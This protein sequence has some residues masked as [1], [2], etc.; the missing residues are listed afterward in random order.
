MVI[1]ELNDGKIRIHDE[2]FLKTEK[3]EAEA[4]KRAAQVMINNELRRMNQTV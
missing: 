3:E 4:L 1:R 2:S